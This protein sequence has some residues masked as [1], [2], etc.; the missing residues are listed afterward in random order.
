MIGE[1]PVL[2]STPGHDSVSLMHVLRRTLHGRRPV[3]TPGSQIPI[4]S[5]CALAAIMNLKDLRPETVEFYRNTL[6]VLADA[7]IPFMVGGA[8]ALARYTEIE[9]YTKDLDLFLPSAELRSAV[10]ALTSADLKTELTHPHWLAKVLHDG[11]T[12]DLIFASGNGVVYVD[13][14]W[15]NHAPRAE[16]LGVETWICPPE[17]TITMKSFVME[18]E[19]Y[20]GA[21]V[22]HMLKTAAGRIDWE[23]L[24]NLFGPHWEVLYSHLILFGY[25]FPSRRGSIPSWVMDE[26]A[27]RLRRLYEQA[28]LHENICRGTL[29]SRAQY[30]H[31]VEQGDFKDARRWPEGTL[32]SDEISAWTRAIEKD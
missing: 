18:R 7:E 12:V 11:E 21:D 15:L 25:I 23:R 32:T 10:E 13:K 31:D 26:L 27:G 9:R 24:I 8:Y 3:L 28:P 6:Q 20:D 29:L 16:V 22:A 14:A 19:R 30:L 4:S 17:E 5:L 2:G 1:R